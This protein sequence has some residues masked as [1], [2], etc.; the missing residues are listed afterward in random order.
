MKKHIIDSDF[1]LL[2][3]LGKY[4]KGKIFK[5]FGGLVSGIEDKSFLDKEYFEPTNIKYK[6]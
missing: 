5:S 6:E 3:N 1:K 4:K 2:K